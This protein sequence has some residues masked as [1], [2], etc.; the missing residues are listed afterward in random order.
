MPH[1]LNVTCQLKKKYFLFFLMPENRINATAQF[2]S[3]NVITQLWSW[4]NPKTYFAW[5][6]AWQF[7]EL[8]A[9]HGFVSH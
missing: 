1:E 4:E 9:M 8:Y 6:P 3:Y 7:S 5:L 2:L